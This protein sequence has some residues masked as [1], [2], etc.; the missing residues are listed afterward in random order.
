MLRRTVLGK[1][2]AELMEIVGDV[3][4]EKTAEELKQVSDESVLQNSNI[5]TTF[6]FDC[7]AN[8]LFHSD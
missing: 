6:S 7:L 4:D 8:S 1:D 3:V 5:L 2:A